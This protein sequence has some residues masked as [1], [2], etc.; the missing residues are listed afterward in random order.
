MACGET[1]VV[2]FLG[3]SLGLQQKGVGFKAKFFGRKSF[4][5]GLCSPGFKNS[6]LEAAGQS[7]PVLKG[8]TFVLLCLS[9]FGMTVH[10]GCW[11]E[12]PGD[13]LVR[14]QTVM[15]EVQLPL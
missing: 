2:G 9:S 6:P 15:L 11:E 3:L 7:G 1:L 14:L 10:G 4:R 13:R 8:C 12:D 5:V